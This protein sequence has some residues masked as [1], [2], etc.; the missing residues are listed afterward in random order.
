MAGGEPLLV[1]DK[2]EWFAR[3]FLDGIGE[4]GGIEVLTN[5]TIYPDGLDSLLRHKN[6][7][8]INVSIDGVTDSKP[9]TNGRSSAGITIKN[10]DTYRTRHGRKP[11]IMTVIT[12]NGRHLPE[13]ARF[14]VDIGAKWEIQANKF[15]EPD[16]DW[17]EVNANMDAVLA[18]YHKA[19][20]PVTD[21]LFN[22]CDLNT[23]R[24]CEN[25]LS[26]FAIMPN[27]DITN[28]QMQNKII[29]HIGDDLISL[30]EYNP[31][32][33]INQNL[34]CSKCLIE[35]YCH[36]DCPY[37]ST[38]EKRLEYICR[39]MKHYVCAALKEELYAQPLSA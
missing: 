29:G 7:F 13:L 38:E 25:G 1:F 9:F 26:M 32:R 20:Y 31:T 5:L 39:I 19:Q 22:F 28:C 33:K 15:Y 34:R 3:E 24:A 14:I 18:V 30:L 11:F 16:F 27:G 36:G 21:I 17:R 12:D 23:A 10:L 4:R 37:K 2:W 8:N 35:D 6:Y